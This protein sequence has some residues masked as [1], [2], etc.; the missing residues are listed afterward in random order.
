M[1]V[2]IEPKT[3]GL[4]PMT[5]TK[6]QAWSV[7]LKLAS[8]SMYP[9]PRVATR[10]M[11]VWRR[12]PVEPADLQPKLILIG[13]GGDTKEEFFA[14]TI[15]DCVATGHGLFM[16]DYTNCDLDDAPDL[17]VRFTIEE[18][19]RVATLIRAAVPLEY[20]RFVVAWEPNDPSVP[21]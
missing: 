7:T 2:T 4:G 5:D 10:I 16:A 12:Q 14:A 20:G 21:F 19:A 13:R 15:L 11:G 8:P 6:G 18:T 9:P 1:E 17:S 3:I